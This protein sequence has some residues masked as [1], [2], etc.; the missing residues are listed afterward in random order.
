MRA[1]W[2]GMRTAGAFRRCAAAL[3]VAA[4]TAGAQAAPSKPLP[5]EPRICDMSIRLISLRLVDATGAP[6]SGASLTVRRVRTRSTLEHTDG[7][8]GQGDYKI[9]EDG[10]LTDLRRDGEP[11]D[12]TF[13]KGGRTK[14][15]R[16]RI[17]MDAGRCHV[18]LKSGP[19]RVVLQ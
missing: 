4:A 1:N 10:V 8:G 16:I 6:V 19:E 13:A 9:L 18:M 12:V 3:V 14:R 5:A 17:G 11:F 7:M 15:V 2:R